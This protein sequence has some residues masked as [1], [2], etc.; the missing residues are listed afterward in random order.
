MFDGLLVDFGSSGSADGVRWAARRRELAALIAEGLLEPD[1]APELKASGIPAA[2]VIRA[3][4][5]KPELLARYRATLDLGPQLDA[6]RPQRSRS[7][8]IHERWGMGLVLAPLSLVAYLWL[9]SATFPQMSTPHRVLALAGLPCTLALM[10]LFARDDVLMLYRAARTRFWQPT[11]ALVDIVIPE[12]RQYLAEQRKPIYGTELP[13]ASAHADLAEREAPTVVTSA[14]HQLRRIVG[15]STPEAVAIA[16]PRGVG[17]TTTIRAIADGMFGDPD[18]PRPLAVL[19]AAP[20]RYEARDFLLHLHVELCRQAIAV[21]SPLL[22]LPRQ[23]TVRTRRNLTFLWVPAVVLLLLALVGG[24]AALVWPGPLSGM[25]A[26]MGSISAGQPDLFF[27]VDSA[28]GRR[29]H[30]ALILTDTATLM[31]NML[32]AGLLA[33]VLG[34]GSYLG[35]RAMW[36]SYRANEHPTL[37]DLRREAFEQLRRVRFLQ[38][39]TS[40]WSGKVGLPMNAEAG[41]SR[42]VQRAEQNMTHPEVVENFRRF[43]ARTADVLIDAGLVERVVIAVD[44]VDKIA[45]PA[46]A[47]E[48]VND[49]KGIFG[50]PGCLFLVS[51]SEDAMSA[52][53]R[54]G[55]P[56]RDAF[57]S[58]FTQMVRMDNFTLAESRRWLSRRLVGV[59]EQFTYLLHCLSGGLP[60]ELHRVTVELVDIVAEDERVD[61][62][63]VTGVLLDR[64][65][66]RKAHAF[67]AAARR[68]D[69]TAELSEYLADLVTMPQARTPGAQLDLAARLKPGEEVTELRRI[70]WQSACFL[71]FCATVREVFDNSLGED[72]DGLESLALARAQLAV[73]PQVAWRLVE[74]V[75]GSAAREGG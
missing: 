14:G 17:K 62:A 7:R 3:V 42:S 37:A 70:R 71:Q 43:A 24:V 54:R 60:R 68:F 59:P 50:I 6:A 21:A 11:D 49:I 39:F 41:W 9:L 13:L 23:E 29:E 15:R 27:V 2:E 25:W 65:L 36:L 30:V 16:G 58:A 48:L 26:R 46:Q 38:T 66:D 64:D 28:A 32:L 74:A 52:F 75:R 47:H 20:S 4:G 12:L 51:V 73:D 67:L 44:E 63:H 72:L 31:A 57:D 61:L 45:D 33:L 1:I 5:N 19:V 10:W 40:G 35:A 18:V 56:V 8:W 69:D 53:E 55:I 22:H 34:R